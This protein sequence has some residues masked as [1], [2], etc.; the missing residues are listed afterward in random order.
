MMPTATTQPAGFDLNNRETSFNGKA[1]SYDANGNLISDGTNTYTWNARN[2]LT[3]VGQGGTAQLSFS[4]DALGRR[5]S[6]AVQG[7][8]AQFLYDGNNAV[9][10]L[11]RSSIN[12]I[13]VKPGV[14]ERFARNDVIGRT[15]FLTD[16][17]NRTIALADQNGAIRQQ[18]S[19]D[20]YG[21]ETQT[22]ATTGF[23]NP[24]QYTGREADTAGLYYHRARYYSPMMAG[25]ISED[26]ITFAGGQLSHEPGSFRSTRA[27]GKL[28]VEGGLFSTS[29]TTLYG[30]GVNST[31]FTSGVPFVKPLETGF[32]TE[33]GEISSEPVVNIVGGE[34]AFLGY[35]GQKYW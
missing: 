20:P 4:Y 19:Y 21:N 5:V 7:A 15:Y 9:Q 10:E 34:S 16:L 11:Q 35:G 23:T 26:P 24:Y 1:L 25:F 12:P 27:D 14:D 2:Q 33:N 3:Q 31:E 22:D 6:K 13:L 32:S 29:F 30:P 8:A 28:G 18:Y 17:L